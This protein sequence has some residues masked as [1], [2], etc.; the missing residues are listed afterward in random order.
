MLFPYIKIARLNHWTKNLFILP[1]ILFAL[2][3]LNGVGNFTYIIFVLAIISV[4]LISSA[5]YVVNEWLDAEFDKFHPTKKDRPAV[6][7]RLKPGYILLEYIILAIVGL[8]LANS[9]SDYFFS[10]SLAFLAMGIVYN[11]SPIRSKDRPYLDVLS[12]SINNPIRL[13]LGWFVVTSSILPPSTLLLGYWMGGA[14][15]M[16]AKRYA[17]LRFI[18]DKHQAALYRRSFRYYSEQNLQTSMI[19]YSILAAFFGAVFMIKY[20]IELLLAFPFFVLLLAWYQKISLRPNSPAQH[21]EQLH[22]EKSFM[23]FIFFLALLTSLLLFF[24]FPF[25]QFLTL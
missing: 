15:L 25:L 17:E 22:Q 19:V 7:E 24:D 3:F 13:L 12:E 6:V 1:G 20:R 16:S 10:T 4:C 14:F 18:A 11:V 23:I 9:V 5:N 21:P 2:W 8:L